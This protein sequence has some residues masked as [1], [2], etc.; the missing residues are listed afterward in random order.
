VTVNV[1]SVYSVA[2]G[3]QGSPVA[4]DWHTLTVAPA[5]GCPEGPKTMSSF[6]DP[7]ACALK[8]EP[9]KPNASIVTA[10]AELEQRNFRH[11]KMRLIQPR[12]ARAFAIIIIS[13]T[14]L[15]FVMSL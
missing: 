14:F 1:A 7:C 6:L 2:S 11:E 12:L 5:I 15:T 10:S 9:D 8:K 4:V 13:R 3:E